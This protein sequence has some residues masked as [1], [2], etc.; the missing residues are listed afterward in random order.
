[1][2]ELP[3][4]LPPA[5]S[6]HAAEIDNLIFSVHWLMLALFIGWGLFF[7]YVLL[8]FRRSRN[9]KADY[10]GSR[11]H[12]STWLEMAVAGV[13]VV[14]LVGFSIPFWVQKTSAF[15][16]AE[17]NPVV[18]RVV[19]QQ[20]AWNIH[21]PGP[22]GIFGKTDID[23]VDE[24]GNPIGLDRSDPAA[25]DDITTINQLH[26]PVDR[27]AIIELSSKDVIHSFFLPQFRVKQD[28]IPGMR[29][30]IHFTP[31]KTTGQIRD[32]LTITEHLPTSRNLDR[33]VSMRDYT[34]SQGNVILAKGGYLNPDAM[35]ALLDA[36]IHEV[37]LSI[38]TPTEIAC[39]QLCGLGHYRM[40]GM[41]TVDTQPQFDAWIAA[42]EAALEGAEEHS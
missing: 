12:A 24:T 26:L 40:K 36:G 10:H 2:L 20:F 32:E 42:Q 18:V 28:T 38:D 21:Y 30:P 3:L 7:I 14:L 22:D 16:P 37:S 1:M 5:G 6:A 4:P 27:P 39:A 31:N 11:S 9:P 34:D 29:I 8:R 19:A 41:L 33:Y 35:A 17:Q 15:P 25:K 23:L 13:E